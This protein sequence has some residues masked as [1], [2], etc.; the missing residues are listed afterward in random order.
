[1]NKFWHQETGRNV[2]Y[3]YWEGYRLLAHSL[4]GIILDCLNRNFRHQLARS[5]AIVRGME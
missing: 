5:Y 1:M 3:V 4:Q 2:A